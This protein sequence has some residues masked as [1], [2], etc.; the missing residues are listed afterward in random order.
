MENEHRMYAVKPIAVIHTNLTG[1]FGLP[2]QFGV[3]PDLCGTIHFTPEFRDPN[4]LRGLEGFSHIWLLWIFSESVRSGEKP[5]VTVRPPRLGGNERVGVFASRSPFR[6]NNIG[7]S[8]VKLER[9]ELDTPDGPVLTVSGVDLM[10][11]TPI[12]DIKPYIPYSDA[13]PDA[14]GGFT[15]ALPDLSLELV[16]PEKLLQKIPP[17]NREELCSILRHDMRP[18]YQNDA[19]RLYGLTYLSYDV[20][21]R[22][23]DGVLTV[24]EVVPR[25]P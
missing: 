15:S 25:T 4:A 12:V 7:M 22:V 3:I 23:A 21:F 14:A 24:C 19:D 9:V 6:P 18:Q 17:E 5:P 8:A 13:I 1:K 16:F 11:G 20:R 10:D 2:R